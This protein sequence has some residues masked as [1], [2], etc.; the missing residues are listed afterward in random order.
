MKNCLED[1]E[2]QLSRRTFTRSMLGSLLTFSLVKS[3]DDVDVLAH[4]VR[5]IV[6]TWLIEMEDV[7]RQLRRTVEGSQW[8]Y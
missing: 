5:P 8:S 6:R 4:T 2:M 3:L 7:T 1:A